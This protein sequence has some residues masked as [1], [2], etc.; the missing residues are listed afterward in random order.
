MGVK[1]KVSNQK[2]HKSCNALSLAVTAHAVLDVCVWGNVFNLWKL[3]GT[4]VHWHSSYKL[5]AWTAIIRGLGGLL[6]IYLYIPEGLISRREC[7]GSVVGCQ[8]DRVVTMF[9]FGS[10]AA[11]DWKCFVANSQFLPCSS[12]QKEITF[13]RDR[14][15]GRIRAGRGS[16]CSIF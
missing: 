4:L 14:T 16:Y 9:A 10:L 11:A 15:P 12:Y 1:W 8:L 5:W 3:I 6:G 2:N 13:A 7:L